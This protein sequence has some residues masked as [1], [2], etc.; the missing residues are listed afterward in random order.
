MKKSVFYLI[1]TILVFT[2]CSDP[3]LETLCTPECINLGDIYCEGKTVYSCSVDQNGCFIKKSIENCLSNQICRDGVC[4]NS[5]CNDECYSENL[6]ICGDNTTV[7]SCGNFDSDICL[8]LKSSNCDENGLVCK[9]GVCIEES[10][11]CNGI[12]CSNHG[13]C[14]EYSGS[15]KCICDSGYIESGLEC[16]E[17]TNPCDYCDYWE[18]CIENECFLGE[19]RCNIG[20]DCQNG[21]LCNSEHYCVYPDLCENFSCEGNSHCET[22][23]NEPSCVCDSGYVGENCSQCDENYYMNTTG[24]CCEN[25][26]TLNEIKCDDSDLGVGR[27]CA[28]QN[29]CIKWTRA[30][31]CN[32]DSTNK[33]CEIVNDD[34]ACVCDSDYITTSDNACTPSCSIEECSEHGV[35]DDSSGYALCSCVDNGLTHYYGEQCELSC[36]QEC[37]I[38]NLKRCNP[39]NQFQIELCS[40]DSNGCRKW[41][42]DELCDGESHF[43]CEESSGD[44]LCSCIE[45]YSLCGE[46]CVNKDSDINNCGDCGVICENGMGCFLGEC[47]TT[48]CTNDSF[49]NNES[50]GDAKVITNGLYSDLMLCRYYENDTL[51]EDKD[52][53]KLDGYNGT[54]RAAIFYEHSDGNYLNLKLYKYSVNGLEVINDTILNRGFAYIEAQIQPQTN[55]SYYIEISG[56]FQSS[57]DLVIDGS[58]AETYPTPCD[59]IKCQVN[60]EGVN[61]YLFYGN[62][63]VFTSSSTLIQ[64]SDINHDGCLSYKKDGVSNDPF[65]QNSFECPSGTQTINPG[66]FGCVGATCDSDQLEPTIANY[67]V[68]PKLEWSGLDEIFKQNLK[69]CVGTVDLYYIDINQNYNYEITMD[70]D[71]N[72]GDMNML[73]LDA[74]IQGGNNIS[75]DQEK[76]IPSTH[77][78]YNDFDKNTQMISFKASTNGIKVIKVFTLYK[79]DK[80]NSTTYS[81]K[82]RRAQ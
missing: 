28:E 79:A 34:F 21:M 2:S 14:I 31:D 65:A 23:D 61:T 39:E 25:I 62:F 17:S 45:N 42:S 7:L 41:I 55:I 32:Y 20:S 53:F 8:E 13:Y 1:I 33:I 44:V 29:G 66:I 9:R 48:S 72:L 26:C 27:R 74:S 58:F 46:N 43:I 18:V 52:M 81:I 11:I 75:I 64:C 50:V 40:E 5:G 51:I 37:D 10:D 38:A 47:L 19:N 77:Y 82:I 60:R 80:N 56:N 36:Q 71:S 4:L 24:V 22:I 57:Y 59:Y 15:P 78:R 69:S 76:Y 6:T 16:V 67:S 63:Y 12:D 30:S 54:I 70:Y 73:L 35:C 49:E 3:K 68:I